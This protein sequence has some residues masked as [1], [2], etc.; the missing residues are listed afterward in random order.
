MKI[1]YDRI[2]DAS[3]VYLEGEIP[4]GGAVRSEICNLDIEEGAVIL[5]FSPTTN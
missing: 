4:P 2:A 5:L 1:S 3:F